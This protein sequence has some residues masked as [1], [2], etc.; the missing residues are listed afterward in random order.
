MIRLYLITE[1]TLWKS[2]S[3]DIMINITIAVQLKEELNLNWPQ[4]TLEADFV[5]KPLKLALKVQNMPK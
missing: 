1:K 2:S 5:N 4:N 3:K